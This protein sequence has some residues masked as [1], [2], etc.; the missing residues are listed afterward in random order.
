MQKHAESAI[1]KHTLDPSVISSWTAHCSVYRSKTQW[2][3]AVALLAVS[4]AVGI[5]VL[6]GTA[7]IP[8]ALALFAAGTLVAGIVVSIHTPLLMCPHCGRRP[9]SLR[10]RYRSP[11]YAKHCEH[12][13]Y[14][15]TQ[16]DTPY[17]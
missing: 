16:P 11:L 7:G 6:R 17:G 10:G 1:P 2:V 3:R 4:G 9:V 14:W 8:Y 15:L 13:Y 12:C 5:L